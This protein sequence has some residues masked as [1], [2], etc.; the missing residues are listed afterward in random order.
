MTNNIIPFGPARSANVK[1]VFAATSRR[2]AIIARLGLATVIAL[3]VF[4]VVDMVL[5]LLALPNAGPPVALQP[6]QFDPAA[7]AVLYSLHDGPDSCAGVVPGGNSVSA[8]LPADSATA[9][10]ALLA[11]CA[12]VDRLFLESLAFGVDAGVVIALASD[13]WSRD[14]AE[15]GRPAFTMLTA[16]F[17]APDGSKRPLLVD[18]A[19]R[20]RLLRDVATLWPEGTGLC[21]DL[22]G[23]PDLTA[24][25]ARGVLRDLRP[26]AQARGAELCIAGTVDAPFLRD[27]GV[28][29]AVDLVLAKGFR[30]P[31][32]AACPAAL[33]R[34]G[35]DT[36][37]RGGPGR[38][39]GS[40]PW[41]LRRADRCR[42]G[43]GRGCSLRDRNGADPCGRRLDRGRHR[44]IEYRDALYCGGRAKHAGHAT[45]RLVLCQP[46]G[47]PAPKC[48]TG[49]VADRL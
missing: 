33:V 3:A 14:I 31:G 34:G 24:A 4:A 39:A 8:Y 37:G 13:D 43:T 48:R 30:T 5:R 32:R 22:S 38:K 18:P 26:L 16:R 19:A 47:R 23:N 49:G 44:G 36:A 41:H 20:K 15:V 17:D 21:L 46:D 2:R 25:E 29:G 1:K 45:G 35:R 28:T 9:R 40:G 10:S 6:G 42:D 7:E 27:A 11:H 12:E